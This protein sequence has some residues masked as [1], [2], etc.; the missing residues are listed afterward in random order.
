MDDKTVRK[1]LDRPVLGELMTLK[2][3]PG[4]EG[5]TSLRA[6]SSVVI[7]F[8]FKNWSNNYQASV[9]FRSLNGAL[10]FSICVSLWL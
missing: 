9:G 5:T 10:S 7:S 6:V 2:T 1:Q 3:V 8:S 4:A